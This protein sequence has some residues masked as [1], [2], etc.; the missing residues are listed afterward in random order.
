MLDA[1]EMLE[2]SEA[3]IQAYRSAVEMYRQTGERGNELALLTQLQ[4]ICDLDPKSRQSCKVERTLDLLDRIRAHREK[5]VVFSYRLEP[6][7]EL[8][9]RITRR[10]GLEAVGLLVGE[11]NDGER[12][13][14]VA[15][16]RSDDRVMALLTSSRVGSEGLTLVEANH[17]L[18]FNQWWNPSAND[19]A[20]DRVVRIGQQRKVRVY[21]FCC[22]GTIEEHMERIF[23]SK[24][25]LFDS[26]V[27]RIAQGEGDGWAR[28]LQ[29]VGLNR[30][31]SEIDD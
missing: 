26:A 16:F 20:R 11:M 5:M 19:Q 27:E 14:A 22:R 23:T 4:T 29:E 17:V 21:R 13:R 8:H 15:R 28:V 30:L 6:L 31:I 2:L 10:W 3:Q 24:R 1:T 25:M 7:R 9:R 12:E 18:L